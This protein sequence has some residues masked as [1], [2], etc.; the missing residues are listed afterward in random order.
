MSFHIIIYKVSSQTHSTIL[1]ESISIPWFKTICCAK[2]CFVEE[3]KERDTTDPDDLITE[4]EAVGQYEGTVARA[5][6]RCR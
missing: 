2:A 1:Y 5:N 6:Q 3:V 4:N